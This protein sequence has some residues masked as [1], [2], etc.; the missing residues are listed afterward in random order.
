MYVVTGGVAAFR[1]VKVGIAGDEYFEVADGLKEGETTVAG[2]YQSVRD[3]KD[4]ARVRPMKEA[5]DTTKKKKKAWPT[6]RNTSPTTRHSRTSRFSR[7]SSPP[8]TTWGA[9][10]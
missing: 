9:R 10:T 2:P 4:S 1:P 3:L 8:T 5:A 7:T 6:S